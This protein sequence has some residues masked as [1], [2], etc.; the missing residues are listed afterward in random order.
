MRVLVTGATGYIGRAVVEQLQVNGHEPRILT[1]VS[2]V[3]GVEAVRGDLL[4]AASVTRAAAGTDAVVHLAALGQ[5]RESFEQPLRYYEVNVGGT[6]NI[7]KAL[8][9]RLVFV[10]TASVYG[11]PSE[12][13]ITEDCPRRPANPYAASKAAA[14]D[15]VAW[16]ALAGRIG[17]ATLRLFN[18]AGGGDRDE[19]RLITRA[20]AVAAGRLESMTVFGDG[21]AIR[22][23]VHVDDIAR[24]AVLALEHCEV[25]RHDVFN[26]GATPA[27]VR[28]VLESV[29]RV[30]G[31]EVPITREPAHP[32][33]VREIRADTTR[34]R[35]ALGWDPRDS[36][37]D[38]LVLDQWRATR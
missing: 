9:R 6:L 10:S 31:R 15:A 18:A 23:F 17:A 30:T 32:G 27:S 13:P 38:Q 3:G 29:A 36:A 12:Q 21:S 14:E 26:V 2:E 16:T 24:A 4:D 35:T 5:I 20:V 33:E 37:L 28:D 19:S 34:I 7:L 22:D 8:P 1:H 11:T 25:G